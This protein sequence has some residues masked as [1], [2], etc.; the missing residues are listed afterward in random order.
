M[1]TVNE[2]PRDPTG[3]AASRTRR[4]RTK[5]RRTLGGA[6]RAFVALGLALPVGLAAFPTASSTHKR[7]SGLTLPDVDGGVDYYARFSRP[8]PSDASYF[9]IGVWFSPALSQA[10]IDDDKDVGL[11]LFVGLE[12][13]EHTN[14]NLIRSN[15][16]NAIVQAD[17]VKLVQRHG[18][19]TPVAG[20][21]RTRST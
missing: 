17:R 20:S 3:A 12:N 8:L 10:H 19:V 15:G 6:L 21:S 16:M 9:P 4:I 13:P 5:R 18:S 14:L 7:G 1:P 11:N 2:S